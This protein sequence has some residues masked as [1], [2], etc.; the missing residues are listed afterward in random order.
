MPETS[1]TRLLNIRCPIMAAPMS[2]HS[3]GT[4]AAGVS[5]AGGLG[6]FGAHARGGPDWLREQIQLARSLTTSPFGVGFITPFLHKGAE[7]FK[8]VLEEEVPVLIFSFSDARE[9]IAEAKARGTL[10]ISQVQSETA[11]DE[12]VSAGADVLVVQ[13]NEA[14]GHTGQAL[15]APLFRSVRAQNPGL[16]ILVAG[17]IA[18]S[19]QLAAA[20]SDGADGASVG[21]V[22][23]ACKDNP[24]VIP[25]RTQRILES[26]A[27]DT[28]YTRV[29]DRLAS[30][31]Q[32][33]PAWPD[34]IAARLLRNPIVD[35]WHGR[36]NEMEQHLDTLGPAFREA[37][38]RRDPD[39]TAV[40][41]GSGVGDI[42]VVRTAAEIIESLCP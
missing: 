10:V 24:D 28:V 5:N 27:D 13:G 12:A 25:E 6:T 37:S 17:G 21:T 19:Q 32:G 40:Y 38:S 30:L 34:G 7:L 36:E 33:S 4:I 41:A 11:A 20:L 15:L 22:F 9:C 16:P 3:G 26:T 14:D 31:V 39:G 35:T 1:F 29:F 8:T 2:G 23:L 18:T 42:T